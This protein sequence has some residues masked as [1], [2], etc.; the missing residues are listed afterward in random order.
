MN[1]Q[2]ATNENIQHCAEFNYHLLRI[3]L[4]KFSKN[5]QQLRDDELKQVHR[6]ASKS[7]QLENR[8]LNSK[9]AKS[10]IVSAAQL[11]HSMNDIRHRYESNDEFHSDMQLNGLDEETLRT[12]LFRELTFDG[13]LQVIGSKSPDIGDL[14]I[15][16]FYQMHPDRFEVPEKRSVRHILIT[17]NDDFIE[18]T[19]EAALQRMSE[20]LQK[21]NHRV[22]RFAQFAKRYSECPTVVDGGTLGDME[23]GN[24]YPEIDE[25]LFSMPENSISSVVETEMGFHI[26]CCDRITPCKKI[27]FNTVKSKIFDLLDQRQRRH[28]QK[29]WLANL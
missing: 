2:I 4:N 14:D 12:A 24:L 15:R 11:E 13:V 6:L 17:V 28:C 21:L 5:I 26:L 22:N 8:V 25:A 16:L 3:A 18:N 29:A 27:P 1:S 19:R 20:V 23:R 9:E 10:F 7:Y